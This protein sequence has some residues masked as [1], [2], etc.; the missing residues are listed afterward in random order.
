MTKNNRVNKIMMITVS[1]LLSLVLITSSVV[2]STFAKY[3]STGK[4]SASARVAK[5]GVNIEVSAKGELPEGIK[6]VEQSDGKLVFTG[7][8]A[9]TDST[10]RLGPGAD[11]SDRIS[12]KFSG[13]AEVALRVVVGFDI[14]ADCDEVPKDISANMASPMYFIP[15]GF[16]FSAYD[17][18]GAIKVEKDFVSGPWNGAS[19]LNGVDNLAAINYADNLSG[20]IDVEADGNCIEKAFAPNE[21]IVFHPIKDFEVDESVSINEFR[22]GFEWPSEYTN[23]NTKYDY[24][25]I[26]DYMIDY[27]A[28]STFAINYTIVIE[29]IR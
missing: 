24:D 29:Q 11:Y 5:W 16:T 22:F 18:A 7:I 6:C 20:K 26:C 4:A 27:L 28:D 2:S 23:S 15:M 12:V 10:F 19:S 25:A 3:V 1:V 21:A 13:T 17:N 9:D 8:T 14:V